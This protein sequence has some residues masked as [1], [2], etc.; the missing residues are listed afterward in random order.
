MAQ[1]NFAEAVGH[2]DTLLADGAEQYRLFRGTA[3]YADGDLMKAAADFADYTR[4]A[5]GDPYGWLWL[6]LADR[7]LG[8][9]DAA[10]LAE[11][12]ARRD[13]WPAIII[14][15]IAGT[16]SAED[17][18]AAADIPDPKLKQLRLAE[19]NFYLGELAILAGDAAG[20]EARFKA[21]LAAGRVRLDDESKLP[22]YKSDDDLE[23]ALAN[24][25]LNGKGL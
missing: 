2:A 25:A 10:K 22:V 17:V 15:H 12:A 16:A 18:L 4:A 23:L 14:R 5:P 7:K 3:R 19:A 24:A 21:S 9:D 1:G 11:V 6:Y 20:A 13:A 8:K